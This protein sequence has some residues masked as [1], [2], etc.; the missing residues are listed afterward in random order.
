MLHSILGRL[1]AVALAEGIS[2]V[3]LLGIAMPL[4]YAFDMPMAVRIFGMM[5]GVLFIAL[6]ALLAQ[7]Q[8]QYRWKTSFSAQVFVASLIPLGAFWMDRKLKDLDDS[9]RQTP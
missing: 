8:L 6:V 7:S 4:K 9:T 3:I 2:Y 5:H 1:R